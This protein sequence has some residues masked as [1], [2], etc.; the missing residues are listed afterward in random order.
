MR[1]HVSNA[2]ALVV[3][4]HADVTM[5]N[6]LGM[7]LLH[8][9]VAKQRTDVVKRDVIAM[10]LSRGVDVGARDFEGSTARDYVTIHR[11]R[12]NSL[13]NSVESILRNT[14]VIFFLNRAR[15][16]Y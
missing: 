14:K 2:N 16:H 13:V 12:S 4:R 15:G 8:A 1:D 6:E 7:T 5:R 10:L 11:V 3:A 9:I